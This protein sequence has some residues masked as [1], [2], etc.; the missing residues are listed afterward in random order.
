LQGTKNGDEGGKGNWRK[1]VTMGAVIGA[2]AA[3]AAA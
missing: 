2:G 3:G 1:G